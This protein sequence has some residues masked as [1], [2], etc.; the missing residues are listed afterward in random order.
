MRFLRTRL[1]QLLT[2]GLIVC[3]ALA[4]AYA[5]RFEGVPP[6]LYRKQFLLVLPYLVLL[7]LAVFGAFRVYRL[8]WRYVTVRDLPRI[9]G[10]TLSGTA[11]LVAVRFFAVP[12][13]GAAGLVVNPVH[14]T[15]PWGVLLSELMLTTM[16]LVAAR[17]MWRL[18]REEVSRKARR[19]D[20]SMPIGRALVIGAGSAGV[21][22]AREVKSNPGAGFQIVGFLDDDPN[23]RGRIVHGLSVLGPS[24]QLPALARKLN[25]DLAI[26]AIGNAPA[27]VVR[28]IVEL[29]ETTA[30]T[31]QIIPELNEILSGRI[32]ISQL[33][34]V[35]IEDLLRREP[36]QLDESLIGEFIS[37]KT[38]LVTGAG[39]SI[40]S[41][42]CR[43][44]CR[45]GPRSLILVEY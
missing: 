43:Q 10:A 16:G 42:M 40:G 11:V 2:D 38:V 7:R 41:E 6:G 44:V 25:A 36:V 31:V 17:A 18:A 32:S 8:M 14:V 33:R 19:T 30:M 26:I 20:A 5:I 15:V 1:V 12:L 13:F 24:D 34:N 21:M 39:G 27:Q 28:R 35:D 29:A 23:K 9:V 3:L 22:I 37:G 45:F 4:L